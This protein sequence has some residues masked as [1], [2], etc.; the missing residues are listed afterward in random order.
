MT[1][2][3]LV[4]VIFMT[5]VMTLAILIAWL[6]LMRLT[7]YAVRWL[8]IS[9]RPGFKVPDGF[10]PARLPRRLLMPLAREC[11]SCIPMLFLWAAGRWSHR[12]ERQL[13]KPLSVPGTGSGKPVLPAAEGSPAPPVVVL[14]PGYLMTSG[15]LW[16]LARH[17]RRFGFRTLLFDAS[18][19]RRSIVE[20]A[21]VLC[22]HAARYV[23]A[24]TPVVLLGHSMGGMVCRLAASRWRTD[25]L[26]LL[27]VVAVG[28][29]H[30]GT[31]LWSL[32]LGPAAR[33]M[34][35][36]AELLAD[37]AR[38]EEGVAYRRIGVYSRFDELVIPNEHGRWPGARA[39]DVGD[40]GHFM[41]VLDRR[42]ADILAAEIRRICKSLNAGYN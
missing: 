15:C 27:G 19:C 35:P 24:G 23:P 2:M 5:M 37:L 30:R 13:G 25:Q 11:F 33:E 3:I 22:D 39:V 41:L 17:L 32:G 14:V 1:V 21:T 36:G 6:I 8:E 26:P 16:P 9:N 12:G 7:A 28:S 34:R 38:A 10:F 40:V 29:P 31:M 42:V 4:T 18:D 20:H